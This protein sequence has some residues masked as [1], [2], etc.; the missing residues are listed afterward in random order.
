MAAPS[1]SRARR[2]ATQATCASCCRCRAA[3][4]VR[5]GQPVF[6]M[7]LSAVLH[8]KQPSRRLEAI[9]GRLSY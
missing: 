5:F 9:A 4:G 6:D 2:C 8:P 3:T 7:L 1:G